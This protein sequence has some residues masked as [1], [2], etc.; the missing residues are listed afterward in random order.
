M[1]ENSLWGDLSNIVPER[2]P[3]HVLEE[4]ATFLQ[5]ETNKILRGRTVR[6]VEQS[7]TGIIASLEVVA[8][9]LNNYSIEVVTL[10]YTITSV[11][12]V[13]V[14]DRISEKLSRASTEDELR[15]ALKKVLTSEAVR[16]LLASLIAESQYSRKAQFRQRGV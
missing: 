10:S 8:P 15:G 4:Q 13:R 9:S 6:T 11:Y 1:S 7:G 5:G 12:P 16:S 2:T 3:S 14:R